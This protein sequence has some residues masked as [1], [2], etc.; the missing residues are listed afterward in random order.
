MDARSGA[1]HEI[2]GHVELGPP[3]KPA[4]V[5]LVHLP[6][7]LRDS[8]RTHRGEQDHEHVFTGA[9]GGVLRR[10]NFR[11][12]FW[13]PAVAGLPRRGW[14]PLLPGFRFHDLRHT[15]KTWLL[16]DAVPEVLQHERLGHRMRGV[17]GIYSHVT[18][19]MIDRM[20]VGL[21]RR[22]ERS[23]VS[24]TES[25]SPEH[26]PRAESHHDRLLPEC[27]HQRREP[28]R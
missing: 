10:S 24:T 14:A 26:I 11:D 12:R 5:R 21:Q 23:T 1:L 15:H 4:S 16:E 6:P 7:F 3:K 20:L 28:R 22:W 25:D 17:A 13:V 2:G 8:L 27:S 9:D 19:D 18:Q